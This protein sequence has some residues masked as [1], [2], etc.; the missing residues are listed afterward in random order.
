[1]KPIWH[2]ELLSAYLDGELTPV[3]RADVERKLAG[4]RELRRRLKELRAV[5]SAVQSL[6][7]FKLEDDFPQQVLAKARQARIFGGGISSG[8]SLEDGSVVK[9]FPSEPPDERPT[10]K[11]RHW[12]AP[13]WVGIAASALI[14]T[15]ILVAKFGLPETELALTAPTKPVPANAAPADAAPGEEA[16]FKFAQAGDQP[17]AA[18]TASSASGATYFDRNS[19]QAG[20]TSSLFGGGAFSPGLPRGDADDGDGLSKDAEQLSYQQA[21]GQVVVC[22]VEHVADYA[23]FERNLA[24]NGIV[25]EVQ[26]EVAERTRREANHP[27]PNQ[28]APDDRAEKYRVYVVDTDPRQ[29]D[30]V[31]LAMQA[32]R[33]QVNRMHW[34]E[35]SGQ[36]GGDLT[37][38]LG[39][40]ELEAAQELQRKALRAEESKLGDV[41][42][43]SG[44]KAETERLKQHEDKRAAAGN[45]TDR[46]SPT[47]ATAGK[48][49]AGK[50][51]AGKNVAKNGAERPA[52]ESLNKKH[53]TAGA[54]RTARGWARV[55]ELPAESDGVRAAI[56]GRQLQNELRRAAERRGAA[57]GRGG[58]EGQGGAAE[59]G[60][61]SEKGV[62]GAPGGGAGP[63]QA[64]PVTSG[65]AGTPE[66]AAKPAPD[67]PAQDK[68]R[69]QNLAAAK[70]EPAA[71]S[72]S[73]GAAP[74]PGQTPVRQA[75]TQRGAKGPDGKEGG[76][77]ADG[78][79]QVAQGRQGQGRQGQGRQGQG[80][81]GQGQGRDAEDAY[82]APQ[83]QRSIVIL[84]LK[85]A[86]PAA[87]PP[88]R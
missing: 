88:P 50:P 18:P 6:P 40:I 27:A 82:H 87:T 43:E 29:L 54:A 28:P 63:A 85:P 26:D 4:D 52:A 60:G 84:R 65:G 61:A 5:Q 2:D 10:E 9:R 57:E 36:A 64:R 62:A 39:G 42:K 58:A 11:A 74:Q 17:P 41:E 7:Q 30:N 79:A 15:T 44:A 56:A 67:K 19:D 59:K 45:K 8:G 20:G 69:P 83:R 53:D 37:E 24:A 49:N 70:R 22:D 34:Y 13:F 12:H 16:Q 77:L 76:K 80:R 31:L 75:P 55:L 32:G 14:C 47:D 78:E 3:Q 33:A 73:A 23:L 38:R 48:P 71:A 46:T 25:L 35:A 81:Q 68:S 72:A 86:A 51:G 66:G 21:A 1:M